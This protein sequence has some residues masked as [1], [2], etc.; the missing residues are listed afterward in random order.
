MSD[1]GKLDEFLRMLN[2]TS[3]AKVLAILGP[4]VAKQL[5]LS[6]RIPIDDNGR[7]ACI[8]CGAIGEEKIV[9]GAFINKVH[10]N[11]AYIYSSC[12]SHQDN[13]VEIESIEKMLMST[14]TK[15]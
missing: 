6:F 7:M 11:R 3:K 13:P 10:P 4:I 12:I 14:M 9:A 5:K 2:E 15:S 8:L 1:P